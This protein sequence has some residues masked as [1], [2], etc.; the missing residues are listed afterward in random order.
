ML[1]VHTERVMNIT[2]RH[3]YQQVALPAEGVCA[4]V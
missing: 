2:G 1:L 4:P 3:D